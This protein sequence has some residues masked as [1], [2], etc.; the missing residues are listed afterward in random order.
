[1]PRDRSKW[2]GPH[3]RT[4]ERWRPYAVGKPCN[5]C[6][7]PMLPGEPVDLDHDDVN[8]GY[9]AP[10]PADSFS[11][12]SC[13]RSAGARDGNQQRGERRA[14][15]RAIAASARTAPATRR[16]TMQFKKVQF[17]ADIDVD[18]ELTVLVAAGRDTDDDPIVIE[19]IGHWPG[20]DRARELAA[21]VRAAGGVAVHLDAV[22]AGT[23][24]KQLSGLRARPHELDSRQARDAL[25]VFT[26]LFK[27]NKIRH[28]PHPVLTDAV[29]GAQVR[30]LAGRDEL[31]L[32]RSDYPPAPIRAAA[33]AVAALLE[34]RPP[35]VHAFDPTWTPTPTNHDQEVT[36]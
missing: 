6:G 4:A 10:H 21:A 3:R 16:I 32:R 5:R 17:G 2:S 26:D 33:F 8:G 31:D 35:R 24:T 18:R 15:T 22:T 36:E 13:N 11:H 27:A 30:K 28:V 19:V 14:R 25:A 12:A 20:G 7:K 29:R 1:M 34:H 9:L 23:L